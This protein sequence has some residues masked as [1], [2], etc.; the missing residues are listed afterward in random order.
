MNLKINQMK[1]KILGSARY[2]DLNDEAHRFSRTDILKLQ[3]VLPIS[4]QVV[5]WYLIGQKFL[6]TLHVNCSVIGT[7]VDSYRVLTAMC[8]TKNDQS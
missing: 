3:G 4:C 5:Y 2:K 8:K 1:Q 6:N 7:P